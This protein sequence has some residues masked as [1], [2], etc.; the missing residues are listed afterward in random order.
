MANI[1]H[2]WRRIMA[3]GCSHGD[4]ANGKIQKQV[5]AFKE[6]FKPEIRV[7]LGDLVDT[8]TFR[9]GA[10]GTPDEGVKIEPDEL[11]A[12]SWMKRYEPTHITFG[13]HDHRLL[14]LQN[15]PNAIV[16]YAASKLWNSLTDT[17]RKMHTK[18]RMY[19]IED[20]WFEIGGYY[21][22]HGYMF[23]ENAVRDH[24]EYLGGPV[25]M[26]HLHVPQQVSGRTRTFTPSYC[27][28]TLANIAAMNYARRRRATSR[29]AHGFVWG[30]V[31]DKSAHLYLC[32]CKRDGEFHLPI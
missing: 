32:S 29:W 6:K 22:G 19:D 14:E 3:Q 16:S 31:S 9:S 25:V 28:G 26:A 27:V 1:N 2:K 18:T 7:E 23:S 10:R 21:W 20:G 12:L 15:S 5:L 24:A 4:L 13:N 17:A 11:H 30:E 8:A